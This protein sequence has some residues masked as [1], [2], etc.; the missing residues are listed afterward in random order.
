MQRYIYIQDGDR[1]YDIQF[2]EIIC[3]ILCTK[4]KIIDVFSEKELS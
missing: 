3:L 4:G 2:A 1:I